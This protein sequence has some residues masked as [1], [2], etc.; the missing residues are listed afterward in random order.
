V[1]KNLGRIV[2]H[3]AGI[4]TIGQAGQLTGKDVVVPLAER[5]PLDPGAAYISDL[6][7]CAV[8]DRE[9]LLG[10]VE[11]VQF[12]TAPDG[13]RRLEEAAPLLAVTSP[14]GEEVLVPY[15]EAYLLELDI[16]G[17]SI[18]M[19]LPEGLAELN[20]KTGRAAEST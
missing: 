16:A 12:P 7:G 20:R 3:F 15:V 19:A 5:M 11:S 14:E 2:L 13:S 17:R 1:G 9:R 18:R 6:I 10:T 4:D 8:F